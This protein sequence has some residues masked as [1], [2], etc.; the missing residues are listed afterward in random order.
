MFRKSIILL[1]SLFYCYSL[2]PQN[3]QDDLMPWNIEI[4]YRKQ[5]E[6]NLDANYH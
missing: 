1:V 6:G 3:S 2:F 5:H 4:H